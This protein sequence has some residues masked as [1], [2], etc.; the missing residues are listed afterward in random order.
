MGREHSEET[1]AKIS[2]AMRLSHAAR[3]E[4][5]NPTAQ[6]MKK[7]GEKFAEGHPDGMSPARIRNY[8]GLGRDVEVIDPIQ[9]SDATLPSHE[10]KV[11]AEAEERGFRSTEDRKV[12][13]EGEHGGT[14][15][16]PTGGGDSAP[17]GR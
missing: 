16:P 17:S 1:K 7:V 12:A 5:N 11:R 13:A 8:G 10:E 2:A 4:R 3:R 9:K 14:I 6:K 15:R